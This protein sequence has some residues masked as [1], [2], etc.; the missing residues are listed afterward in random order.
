MTVPRVITAYT[1]YKSPYAYL[2]KD[3]TYALATACGATVEWKPY[4]LDI[5]RYLGSARVDSAGNVVEENP[6]LCSNHTK[7]LVPE[8]LRMG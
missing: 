7:D 2:A 1:D 4:V 6:A 8:R 5:P 3:S